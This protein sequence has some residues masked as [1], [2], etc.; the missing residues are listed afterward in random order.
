MV[1]ALNYQNPLLKPLDALMLPNI[2]NGNR[3]PAP[4][5]APMVRPVAPAVVPAPRPA[6]LIPI[7]RIPQSNGIVNPF[8]LT[9]AVTPIQPPQIQAPKSNILQDIV[10]GLLSSGQRVGGTVAQGAAALA[11]I[12]DIIPAAF[13]DENAMR[14]AQAKNKFINDVRQAKALDG[15][16]MSF[17]D[18]ASQK[19]TATPLE[20]AKDFTDAGVETANLIPITKGAGV[21]AKGAKEGAKALTKET[22]KQALKENA[23]QALVYGGSSTANDALQERLTPEGT[24]ANFLAPLVLGTGS[25]LLARGGKDA[26]K[27]IKAAQSSPDGQRGSIVVP[28]GKASP[29]TPDIP[30]YIPKDKVEAYLKSSDY[31][32]D[33]KLKKLAAETKSGDPFDHPDL[34][35][36]PT[37]EMKNNLK[38]I[39]PPVTKTD[40]SE[41]GS[42]KPVAAPVKT[43]A[44]KNPLAPKAKVSKVVP[45][46]V[47]VVDNVG[48]AKTGEK[49]KSVAKVSKGRTYEKT[50]QAASKGRGAIEAEKVNYDKFV[51]SVDSKSVPTTKQADTARA[52]QEKFTPG[53]AE[54]K[55]LGKIAGRNVTEAAQ[56][57]AVIDR[58]VRKKASAKE[59]TTR[60]ANKLYTILDDDRT[61][62]KATFKP[63]EEA[64]RAF[65]VARKNKDKAYNKFQ[66]DPSDTNLRAYE[67]ASQEFT[68]ADT[69]SLFEEYNTVAKAIK[70]GKSK[71]TD[72]K[73]YLETLKKNSGIYFMD[74]V[75]SNLLS[76][77]RVMINNYVNTLGVG[78]EEMLFGKAGAALGRKLV[79][80]AKI[81]GGSVRGQIMGA[82][83]G[84]K[85]TITEA[86]LRQS[87]HQNPVLKTIANFTTTG[88]TLGDHNITG[89]AYASAYDAYRQGL[90]AKGF[91]GAELER[92]AK[93]ATLADIE[94][95]VPEAK[96]Q[97]LADVG[98]ASTFDVKSR[99]IESMLAEKLSNKMGNSA[100]AKIAAKT[101]VRVT[102]GFPTVTIRG[103]IGGA[104]RMTLGIPTAIQAVTNAVTK[105]D[106]NVTARLIKNSVKEFGS[107]ATMIGTGYALASTGLI[108]GAY[109]EDQ[110]Q[111]DA[112]KREG[113]TDYSINING[114]W[115]NLPQAL[116]VFALPF[117]IGANAHENVKNGDPVN[118]DIIATSWE[119]ILNLSPVDQLKAT[120]E[121]M[122]KGGDDKI[123]RVGSSIT[124]AVTPLGSLLN[125]VAKA[126]DPNANDTSKGNAIEQFV[127]KVKDGIPGIANTLEDK[128]VEGRKIANPSPIARMLGAVSHEQKDGVEASKE[129]KAAT[130]A[131]NKS[132]TDNGAFSDDIRNLMPDD[133][134]KALFD[135]IKSGKN[136]D[137]T[138]SKKIHEAI[139]KNVNASEDTRF[140]ENGNYDANLAVLKVKK[141]LLAADPTTR[142]KALK[143]YDEQI[144]RGQVYK[145]NKTPYELT[146]DYSKTS[147]SEWRKMGDPDA[148]EYN[149]EKYQALWDL[150][151][152]LA[153]A[154]GSRNSDD[155][156]A[157]KFSA[158]KAG[159]GGGGGSGSGKANAK[160]AANAMIAAAKGAPVQKLA[161]APTVKQ[162]TYRKVPVSYTPKAS[163]NKFAPITISARSRQSKK[164]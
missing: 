105:G 28:G 112:W 10:M 143:E 125:Q 138:D 82:K 75:D 95:K 140:L 164:A 57:L 129:I 50:S 14:N 120:I 106:P 156:K 2:P 155:P 162:A 154:G 1:K 19:G 83:V 72:A 153:A 31:K 163:Q 130:V 108:S 4:I 25:E 36:N 48:T 65:E 113:K 8:P 16:S 32:Q 102:I 55:Q 104:K 52:L 103:A 161:S 18:E 77:T 152:K 116:G 79:P 142:E 38:P 11:T 30:S 131:A 17:I 64:N 54:H 26:A 115:W 146:Q 145:D 96:Q 24:A 147:L 133:E 43:I 159:S 139:A 67:R 44:A 84:A 117:M 21:L 3:P 87:A 158:K 128:E 100:A 109:P 144:A 40:V 134:T 35:E 63:V 42:P 114:D 137:P 12:P 80:N 132:L 126:F 86:K 85:E 90:K 160:A 107:G 51:K 91:K 135:N 136:T 94:G 122:E 71:N 92:R 27:V 20:F 29:E 22:A 66:A 101:L 157:N 69:K 148:D 53:T 49:G 76:S 23:M 58:N 98:L 88:N 89:V 5:A 46:E 73:K 39:K 60:F 6:P 124:K 74:Y 110:D 33:Q 62:N 70:D 78:A 37:P 34:Y 123:A 149:P 41:I 141:D 59:I 61:V 15:G 127:S 56:T 47:P 7:N 45:E 111:R 68:K 150:D 97:A 99:K 151:S 121:L 118:K 119:T 9:P 81:G 93:V 13:G